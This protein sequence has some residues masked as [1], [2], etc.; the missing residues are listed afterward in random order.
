M[1]QFIFHG[2][3]GGALKPDTLRRVLIKE[4]IRPLATKFPSE[5]GE[6]GFCD[7]R[8]HSFRHAFCSTCANHGVPERMLMSWLGH[9]DSAMIRSI[10]T[11]MMQNRA[12]E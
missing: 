3:R 5:Y 7:G 12:S 10:T 9:R 4:V 11:C 8:L 6:K 2:P 1:D